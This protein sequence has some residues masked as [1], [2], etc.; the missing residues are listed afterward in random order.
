MKLIWLGGRIS[1][2]M[3]SRQHPRLIWNVFLII[4][5]ITFLV[6]FA[7]ILHQLLGEFLCNQTTCLFLAYDEETL[8]T[9]SDSFIVFYESGVTNNLKS[10]EPGAPIDI[11]T[12]TL[13]GKIIEISSNGTI[14][15]QVQRASG[16]IVLIFFLFFILMFVSVGFMFYAINTNNPIGVVR[17]IQRKLLL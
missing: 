11:S 3:M 9:S 14:V 7:F 12:S 16:T 10:V 8:I 13:T 5:A 15:Y 1:H 4:L 2:S 6:M 17:K